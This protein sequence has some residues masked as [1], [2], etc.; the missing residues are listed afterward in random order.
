MESAAAQP[1]LFDATLAHGGS[2]REKQKRKA[3]LHSALTS[4]FMGQHQCNSS[5][6]TTSVCLS[7]SDTF[8]WRTSSR[9]CSSTRLSVR[10]ISPA[11]L[12]LTSWPSCHSAR[13]T[14]LSRSE[15]PPA[16]VRGIRAP[17]CYGDDKRRMSFACSLQWRYHCRPVIFLSSTEAQVPHAVKAPPRRTVACYACTLTLVVLE[18]HDERHYHYI[19]EP[20]ISLLRVQEIRQGLRQQKV[21]FSSALTSTLMGEHQRK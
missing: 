3:H 8:K 14:D 11:R 20:M 4:T 13:R 1:C 12:F 2:K 19:Y 7:A 5:G 9:S 15:P 6:D 21:Q 10:S 16:S 17:F 18:A